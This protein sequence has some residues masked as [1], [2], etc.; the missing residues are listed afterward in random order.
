[1]SRINVML[2]DDHNMVREG[3]KQ[4]IETEDDIKVIA[5]AC[6]GNQAIEMANIYK[7]DIILMDIN[8]PEKN[9]IEAIKEIKSTD[10]DCKI[11]VLTIHH[12]REYLLKTIELGAQGYV[13][14]DS[15]HNILISAIRMVNNGETF[16]Q[17]NMLMDVVKAYENKKN[18]RQLRGNN[19]TERELEVLELIADGLVNKN[20]AKTLFISEKTVKNH[21]SNIFKKINVTDRTQAAI[22]AFKNDIKSGLG[23]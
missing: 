1:M 12:E 11:I 13:L 19:L 22:Y 20:I 2:V 15:D 3:I 23:S 6:N 17:P 8:M 7:P 9:G 4:L 18:D 16:I 5:Q 21:I 10:E 14:K